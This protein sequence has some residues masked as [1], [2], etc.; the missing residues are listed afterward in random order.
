MNSDEASKCL[1]LGK[2]YFAK[3]EYENVLI[4]ESAFLNLK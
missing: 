1:Q 2:E 3:G 4:L